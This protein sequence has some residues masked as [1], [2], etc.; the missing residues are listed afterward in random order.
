MYFFYIRATAVVP[1]PLRGSTVR[2]LAQLPAVVPLLCG[3]TVLD[4]GY[5][6]FPADV[7]TDVLL[8]TL[9][10]GLGFPALR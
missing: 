10:P 5:V 7:G 2:G 1:H 6:H 8:S 9:F 4:F 3:S